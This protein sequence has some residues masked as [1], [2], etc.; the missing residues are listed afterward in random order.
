MFIRG[1]E[2]P[3]LPIINASSTGAR[4]RKSPGK[5]I[6]SST[7][8]LCCTVVMKVVPKKWIARWSDEL[9]AEALQIKHLSAELEMLEGSCGGFSAV[10][11]FCLRT[12]AVYF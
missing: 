8:T 4:W 5:L 7:V 10:L 1:S 3:P 2:S 6:P 9:L 12:T 11:F